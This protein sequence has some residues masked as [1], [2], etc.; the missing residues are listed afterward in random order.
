MRLKN[1]ILFQK[2]KNLTQKSS[3]PH[4][5]K[6]NPNDYVPNYILDPKMERGEK[7]CPR[8]FKKLTFSKTQIHPNNRSLICPSTKSPILLPQMKKN[9][10]VQIYIQNPNWREARRSITTRGKP[11]K[12]FRKRIIIYPN[13]Q[14]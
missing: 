2:K 1:L 11:L 6:K 3:T 9:P 10:I 8:L 12:T 14:Q 4:Q 13:S 5:K 7:I